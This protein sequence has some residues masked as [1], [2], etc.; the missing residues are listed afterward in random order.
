MTDEDLPRDRRLPL[1]DRLSPRHG[2]YARIIA[3]HEAAMRTGAPGYVD[4]VS[5]FFVF[6]AAE[7]WDRGVCCN[8]GCRHCP[9]DD[10]PRGPRG[11]PPGA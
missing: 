5:G 3:A 1:I 8:S 2:Q 7:H 9:Y 10:G 11:L 4:P 6:T